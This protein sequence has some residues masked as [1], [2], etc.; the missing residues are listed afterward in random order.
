LVWGKPLFLI[1][2]LSGTEVAAEL[3][4]KF[5]PLNV[6]WFQDALMGKRGR[7][8]PEEKNDLF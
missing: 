6:S 8:G 4:I 3:Q 7:M 5:K 2:C 1:D